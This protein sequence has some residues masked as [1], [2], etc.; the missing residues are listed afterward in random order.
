MSPRSRSETSHRPTRL[1]RFVGLGLL[2]VL[3]CADTTTLNLVWPSEAFEFE[4]R[5]LI[6]DVR[7][8]DLAMA[9]PDLDVPLTVSTGTESDEEVSL[10]LLLYDHP[11]AALEL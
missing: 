8:L 10:Y 7:G 5:I 11:P 1:H 3:G 4:S 6:A 2:S 9:Q